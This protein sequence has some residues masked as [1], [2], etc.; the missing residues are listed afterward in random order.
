MAMTLIT[1]NT[2]SS[3]SASSFTSSIDS[4]YKLYIFKII[5]IHPGTDNTHLLWQ[6]STD[7]GS[8]WGVATTTNHFEAYHSEDDSS[9]TLTYAANHDAVDATSDLRV[10]THM[11]DANDASGSGEFHLFNPSNTTYVKHFYS[12][13]DAMQGGDQD[14]L[15]SSGYVNTT[16]A[17]TA[18][19]FYMSSGNIDA[20]TIK[21]YGVG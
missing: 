19:K 13:V 4:T 3:S 12:T 6:S 16:S 7:G 14:N 5:N 10:M 21:M 18:I 17:I 1:T 15:F 8:N 2:S 20:G 11:D 9:A